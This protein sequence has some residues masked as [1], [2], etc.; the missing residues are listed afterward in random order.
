MEDGHLVFDND[1]GLFR[2]RSNI[3]LLTGLLVLDGFALAVLMLYVL[4]YP[5]ELTDWR[6]SLAFALPL[7]GSGF[8]FYR[9]R[10]LRRVIWYLRV[11]HHGIVAYDYTR[12]KWVIP[13]LDMKAIDITD[14]GLTIFTHTEHR[15]L[16]IP[17]S[18]PDYH[19]LSHA[20]TLRAEEEGIP[21]WIRGKSL[22]E[23]TLNDLYPFLSN[24]IPSLS[25]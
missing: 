14:R 20:L 8:I 19:I 12:R 25:H 3:M 18:F 17:A 10:H 6:T 21:L 7:L 9:I 22:E 16:Y 2:T 11:V 5:E 13:W 15:R 4:A 23:L 1:E 24:D